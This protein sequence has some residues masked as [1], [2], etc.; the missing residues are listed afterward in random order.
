MEVCTV[1]FFNEI[2][3]SSHYRVE[4]EF[5]WVLFVFQ[6]L[7]IQANHSFSTFPQLV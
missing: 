3:P 2:D 5:L 1:N 6:S 7:E 4:V